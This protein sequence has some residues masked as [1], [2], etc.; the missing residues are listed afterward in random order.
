ML[1]QLSILQLELNSTEAEK[2][3]VYEGSAPV[4]PL[5]GNHHQK[6]LHCLLKE[7]QHFA[8]VENRCTAPPSK[9]ESKSAW[10]G[11]DSKDENEF[12]LKTKLNLNLLGC[13]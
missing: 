6:G 10:I 1:I 3:P 7:P 11:I 9:N 4:L 2:L 5:K 13:S 8:A 12:K